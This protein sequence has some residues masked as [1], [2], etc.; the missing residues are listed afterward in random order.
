VKLERLAFIAHGL[1]LVDSG[2]VLLP[3]CEFD[4]CERD[5]IKIVVRQCDEAK[6]TA[7]QL[8]NFL[9]DAVG[10]TLPG[11]LSIRAPYGT[12]RAVL[13]ASAHR[14]DRR[15]HIAVG[16]Q[17]I[18]PSLLEVLRFDLS[19]VVDAL[20]SAGG[21]VA[22]NTIPDDVAV[23]RH[24]H[25]RAAVLKRLFRIE[26]G[27]DS[28]E[29]NPGAPLPC[30]ASRFVEIWNSISGNRQVSKFADR[31]KAVA[32]IW[33]AIQPIAER[34]VASQPQ[35]PKPAKG[36][37][38]AKKAKGA[39]KAALRKKTGDKDERRNKKAEVIAMM[40]RAKGATLAQI[41]EATGW[42]KHT[43]RGFVSLLGSKGGEKIESS[44][45]TAGDRTYR[46]VK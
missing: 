43:I 6:T 29:H 26:R 9:N 11:T 4:V 27:M 39:K 38:P 25:M 24:D 13:G 14:L 36:A 37:K 41:V 22:E 31:K 5:R 35:E 23:A 3:L 7:A 17:Q 42:Q 18:P 28:S 15:P 45:N 16:R 30:G 1:K 10:G 12:E 32:R 19:A 21:A 20:Q 40:K 34:A 33:A 2:L 46:I 44:K 8:H